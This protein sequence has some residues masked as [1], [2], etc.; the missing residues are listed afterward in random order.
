MHSGDL[1]LRYTSYYVL[2]KALRESLDVPNVA[3]ARLSSPLTPKPNIY[4]PADVHG[5]SQGRKHMLRV[6]CRV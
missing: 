4:V 6:M 5:K 3:I 1:V 2:S